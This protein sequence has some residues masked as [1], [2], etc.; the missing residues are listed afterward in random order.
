MN[1]NFSGRQYP[2]DCKHFNSWGEFLDWCQEHR[3]PSNRGVCAKNQFSL[4]YPASTRWDDNLGLD[5]AFQ[6][7]RIGWAEGMKQ[8]EEISKP[9]VET[10]VGQLERSDITYDVE[11]IAVDVGR[12]L[13]EEP[14]CWIR[15]ENEIVSSPCASPRL[16]TIVHNLSESSRVDADSIMRKGA[17]VMALIQALE[18]AGHRVELTVLPF[19]SQEGTCSVTVK[20]F[21]QPLDSALAIYALAH[22]S[23]LRRLGF[24]YAENM[25]YGAQRVIGSSYGRP[26]NPESDADIKVHSRVGVID[27][28]WIVNELAKQGV[29]LKA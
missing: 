22:P 25:S 1:F 15:F 10:I 16:I 5:G 28:A 17:H 26:T 9:L 3:Q 29:T 21:D 19:A 4:N 14:E 12:F 27:M 2:N 7:A 11:G 23:V 8:A 13:A 20:Q 6:M 24:I 18:Y